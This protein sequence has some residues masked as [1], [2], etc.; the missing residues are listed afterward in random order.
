MFLTSFALLIA[1]QGPPSTPS[2][3]L[4]NLIPPEFRV[5]MATPNDPRNGW[6]VLVQALDTMKDAGLDI[7]EQVRNPP[8]E[9]LARGKAAQKMA[10]FLALCEPAFARL[11]RASRMPYLQCPTDSRRD[12]SADYGNLQGLFR[13]LSIKNHLLEA[14][15][16]IAEAEAGM[17][18]LDRLGFKLQIS[19]WEELSFW[20]AFEASRLSCWDLQHLTANPKVST[21]QLSIW[22]RRL[23]RPPERKWLLGR[24]DTLALQDVVFWIQSVPWYYEQSRKKGEYEARRDQNSVLERNGFPIK[25]EETIGQAVQMLQKYQGASDKELL[26]RHTDFEKLVKSIRKTLPGA[27]QYGNPPVLNA[28]QEKGIL[29]EASGLSDPQGMNIVTSRFSSVWNCENAAMIVL[30]E[31]RATR[32]LMLIEVFRR[33]N[34]RLPDTL[35]DLVGTEI[36]TDLLQDPFDTKPF[37]Y[38]KE[39]KLMWSIG[40]YNGDNGGEGV[41]D[42]GYGNDLVWSL[43]HPGHASHASYLRR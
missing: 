13:L 5:R 16:R 18:T 15:G 10:A 12:E 6:P 43:P 4:A 2:A 36:A 21:D 30:A 9:G 3:E 7:P 25:P 34:G 28:E 40:P 38:S 8:P 14:R 19:C 24:M 26:A 29:R 37:R 17:E 41:V 23:Q 20:L 35:A 33:A 39:R 42:R 31:A 27:L 22:V 1:A 11:N 32:I